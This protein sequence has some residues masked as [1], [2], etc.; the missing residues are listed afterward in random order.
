MSAPPNRYA[1]PSNEEAVATRLTI[2][3]LEARLAQA[4]QTLKRAQSEVDLLE[5]DLYK[6]R[7]W[8]SPV[9]H[10]TH[11]ILSIIFLEATQKD[12]RAPF[13]LGGVCRL[14]RQSML[15]TPRVW[16]LVHWNRIKL[17]AVPVILARGGSWPIH[18]TIAEKLD[19]EFIDALT[20]APERVTCLTIS[21]PWQ[22]S[23]ILKGFPNLTKL[24]FTG[25][26]IP[27]DNS[28]ILLDAARFPKLRSLSAG[29]LLDSRFNPPFPTIFPPI[30]ELSIETATR[31]VATE[32]IKKLA[33][34][35]TRLCFFGSGLTP[36]PHGFDPDPPTELNFPKLL[37]L[38]LVDAWSED[39]LW[40][41]IA[42][43]PVLQSY[44][45]NHHI[46]SRTFNIHKD[47]KKVE[48]LL[49]EK[50]IDMSLFP[51]LREACALPAGVAK[52]LNYLEE[53]PTN[54][55]DL[56]TVICSQQEITKDTSMKERRVIAEECAGL[57][58]RM[59]HFN[60]TNERNVNLIFK[61]NAYSFASLTGLSS[62]S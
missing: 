27:I 38:S 1:L 30:E 10:V 47:T 40:P 22:T 3:D 33:P 6:Q 46:S 14:W 20:Q 29:S 49:F 32:I 17:E 36:G 41:F 43:T 8:I 45:E 26:P 44:A 58:R 2:R 9:R 16:S 50:D 18:L 52:L 60:A 24:V 12:D 57:E 42:Q 35:L 59:N 28:T 39:G 37:H 5:E 21:S 54:W 51:K 55:P 34:G 48:A 31:G 4:K 25:R 61:P 53:H 19:G 56:K 62:V 23:I 15:D 7:N 13:V 11:D